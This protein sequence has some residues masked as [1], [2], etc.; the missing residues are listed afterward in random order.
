ML[1]Q[2]ESFRQQVLEMAQDMFKR[3]LVGTASGNASMRI[4]GRELIAITP[5]RV[6]YDRLTP[7]C[8]E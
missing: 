8:N 6:P 7:Y 4:P 1:E 5:T 2:W 3:G